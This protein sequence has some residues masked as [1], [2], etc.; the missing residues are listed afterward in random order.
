ML[1]GIYMCFWTGVEVVMQVKGSVCVWN[2]NER[3]LQ[4]LLVTR[5]VYK[6]RK[7]RCGKQANTC[8]QFV[9]YRR[10]R[11]VCTHTHTS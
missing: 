1:C 7:N 6:A 10:G 5:Q 4:V 2:V 3:K 9:M 11:T 8:T